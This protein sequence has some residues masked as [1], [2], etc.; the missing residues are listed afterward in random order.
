MR[1]NRIQHKYPYIGSSEDIL[2][3]LR[4]PPGKCKIIDIFTYLNN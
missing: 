1:E 3:S 2:Y 4:G